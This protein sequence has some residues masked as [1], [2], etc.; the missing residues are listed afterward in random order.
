MGEE[1]PGVMLIG[2]DVDYAIDATEGRVGLL[3]IRKRA[4]DESLGELLRDTLHK[5]LSCV[6]E[7]EADGSAKISCAVD[8]VKLDVVDR[9]AAENTAD[10]FLAVKTEIEP[11][12]AVLYGDATLEFSRCGEDDP[13]KLLAR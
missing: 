2:H 7:I 11:V 13:R 8:E 5:A 4:G 6:R 3:T 1:G 12:L 9:L 10:A